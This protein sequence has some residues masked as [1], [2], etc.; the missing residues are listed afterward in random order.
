MSDATKKIDPSSWGK[1]VESPKKEESK[2]PK[3]EKIDSDEEDSKTP[4]K[5]KKNPMED[6]IKLLMD[7]IQQL[8][9][10]KPTPRKIIELPEILDYF[11]KNGPD[12][13][14][15]WVHQRNRTYVFSFIQNC[16]NHFLYKD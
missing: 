6:Q 13:M 3:K 2:K 4:K 11:E 16:V 8:E 9:S 5:E 10:K 7:R 15:T 12:G 14:K 1:K